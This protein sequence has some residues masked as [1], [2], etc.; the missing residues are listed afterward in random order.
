MVHATCVVPLLRTFEP[1]L[2]GC[3]CHKPCFTTD[4]E[5]QSIQK[6]T[7]LWQ[8]DARIQD[9]ITSEMYY[10]ILDLRID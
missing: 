2:E 8:N 10:T 6:A 1:T 9:N 7:Y 4:V 3:G 5:V